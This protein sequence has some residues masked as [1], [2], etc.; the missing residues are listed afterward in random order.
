MTKVLAAYCLP[1]MT[2]S[3]VLGVGDATKIASHPWIHSCV[4]SGLPEKSEGFPYRQRVL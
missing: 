4:V 3:S 2:C 1:Y